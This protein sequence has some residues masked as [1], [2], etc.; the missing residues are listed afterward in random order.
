MDKER[1]LSMIEICDYLGISRDT[2]IKWIRYKSM[3][4]HKPGKAWKFKIEE[5]DTWVKAQENYY[6]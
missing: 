5:I 6:N 1:W 3:P 4:A 2:A